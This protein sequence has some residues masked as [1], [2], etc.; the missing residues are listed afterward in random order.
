M[1]WLGASSDSQLPYCSALVTSA[2]HSTTAWSRDAPGPVDSGADATCAKP[3]ISFCTSGSSSN[4]DSLSMLI[5]R[6]QAES[7]HERPRFKTTLGCR[8]AGADRHQLGQGSL[9]ACDAV[10]SHTHQPRCL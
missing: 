2:R 9:A 6:R 5:A 10:A 7:S 4:V 8:P 3:K 1:P